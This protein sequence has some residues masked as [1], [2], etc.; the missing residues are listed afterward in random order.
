MIEYLRHIAVFVRVAEE[1]SFSKAARSLG[2]APSRVS[3]SVSKLEEFVGL[4]L[5]NRTTRKISLTSEG[6][7]LFENTSAILEDAERGIN[8]LRQSKSVLKG[9]LK[10]AAPTYL[11]STPLAQ[12]I[13]RFVA[14]NPQVHIAAD[15]TDHPVDPIQDGY[16]VC[17]RS[18]HFDRQSVNSKQLSTF[19]RVICAGTGY[20]TNR[21]KPDHPKGLSGW[22][23]ITYRHPKRSYQLT[24]KG[25]QTAKLVIK[26]E[27]RLQVDSI[28]ALYTFACMDAGVCVMPIEHAQR[29]IREGKIARL[30]D[31]WELPKVRYSAVWP[32]NSHRDGLSCAFVDFVFEHMNG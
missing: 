20:L 32:L 5:I 17:I 12:A 28:E 26:D 1:G 31:D 27:A 14:L 15:F 18:G 10:I 4:T 24:S 16:D 2:I 6:R 21:P 19:E 11:S 22:D 29:G 23:W 8:E 30:F 25:G 7:T 3:E 9:S 13:G